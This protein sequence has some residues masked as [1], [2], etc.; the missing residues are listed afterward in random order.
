MTTF[1]TF[2]SG[3]SGN[4]A[5][6]VSGQTRVLIDMGISCRRI[7]QCLSSAGLTPG[8]LTAILITHEHIDHKRGLAVFRKKYAVPVYCTPGTARQLVRSAGDLPLHTVR[9]TLRLPEIGVGLLP[10]SH[11]CSE[12]TAFH[13]TT[14]DGRIG[15]LTD[16]GYIPTKT[17]RRML[18]ADLL[19]LESNYDLKMLWAGSYSY[20]LKVR[21]SSNQGH[22]SN[23][24]AADFAVASVRAGTRT[25]L[26]AHLSQEN[27][28][29][30]LALQTVGRALSET[31]WTG[32][33]EVAPCDTPS[34]VYCLEKTPCS[35][36]S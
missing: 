5:L 20:P 12:S 8:D 13:F 21:I 3:S 6:L 29:P 30:A 35:E 34:R 28:T 33:L 24:D 27:N 22:L 9:D 2:A 31:G 1:R 15:Y 11:D 26:L 4:A 16:T 7:C 19:V 18:G 36:S 25:V 23:A 32:C 17:A 14:P 10:T